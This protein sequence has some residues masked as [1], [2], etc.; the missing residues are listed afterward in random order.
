MTRSDIR[1]RMTVQE[2][3]Q[4]EWYNGPVMAAEEYK[5]YMRTM[6]KISKQK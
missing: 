6:I 5:K 1:K 2:V 4:S 3:K